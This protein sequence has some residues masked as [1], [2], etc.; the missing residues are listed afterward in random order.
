MDNVGN[1]WKRYELGDFKSINV[2]PIT[3]RIDNNFECKDMVNI[4]RSNC[5]IGAGIFESIFSKH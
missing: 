4:A 3:I 5:A 1:L 2:D